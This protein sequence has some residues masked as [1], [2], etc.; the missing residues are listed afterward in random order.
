MGSHSRNHCDHGNFGIDIKTELFLK[1]FLI[2]FFAREVIRAVRKGQIGILLGI[3]I[4]QVDAVDDTAKLSGIL[5]KNVLQAAAVGIGLNLVCIIRAD[6]GDV[7]R[8]NNGT[9]GQIQQTVIFNDQIIRTCEVENILE[10]AH[11]VDTLIF[12]IMNGINGTDREIFGD[13]RIA[14]LELD[15]GESGLPIVRVEDIGIE[16]DRAH[17]LQNGN[18]EECESF[19]VVKATVKTA[20]S[21][22]IFVIKEV[23]SNAVLFQGVDSAVKLTPCERHHHV[24]NVSHLLTPFRLDLTVIRHND[25]YIAF[26]ILLFNCRGKRAENVTQAS[27]CRK[28]HNLATCVQNLFH[29]HI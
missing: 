1:R 13:Q 15:H 3:V 21:E 26:G 11:F 18:G 17:K 27:R 23:I 12:D 28:G 29:F 16:I 10:Q 25:T 5:T 4:I 14:S 22:V 9:L 2:F 7:I 20:S 24:F 19:R 6:G 8:A